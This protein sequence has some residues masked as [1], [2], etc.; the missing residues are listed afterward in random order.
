MA[1]VGTIVILAAGA[2]TR[3]L[4]ARP[5]VCQPLC[6]RTLLGWVLEQAR[7]LEPQ[8]I[9]LVVGHG[10]DEVRAAAEAE[11]RALGLLERL[12]F[13]L[14]AERKGTG[15]AVLQALPEFGQGDPVVVL[16]GDMPLLT[17]A[18][19]EALCAA[20]ARAAM[21]TARVHKPRGFGRIVRVAGRFARV[22]EEKDCTREEKEIR[23]VN[24]GVYAFARADLERFLPGLTAENAQREYY[25]TDVPALVLSDGGT[26]EALEL[27]DE[28]E[29]I[30]VNTIEHLSE[31]RSELQRRILAAHMGRGVYVE[32]PATTFIDHGV[33]IGAGAR[34]LPCTVIRAGVRVGKGC[35]VGPFTHLRAGTVLEDGAEVGNFTEAKNARIGEHTKAKH[36]SYLGDV[37]IGAHANIGAGTIVANYDG[38]KKHPTVIGERAFVGSGS[39]LIAPCKVGAGALTGGGAVV[40]RNSE[41]PPGEAWVGVPARPLIRK[42][43]ES[44]AGGTPPAR[45]GTE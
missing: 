25:L 17:N 19:L 3:F 39:V 38:Q 41:I 13:V 11:G 7:A 26:V 2:G 29:A 21:L 4:S 10:A 31:A 30:G 8:R 12:R 16:Y 33:E 42:R 6:G 43:N 5:K 23:E 44:G 34:I 35:E 36:L 28:R 9:V 27:E 18:S 1:K 40:T 20:R 22:V 15:H 24:L 32:D 45:K 37:T 14:Q